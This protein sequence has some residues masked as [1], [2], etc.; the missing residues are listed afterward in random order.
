MSNARLEQ[1]LARAALERA[2]AARRRGALD[3]ALDEL[4]A[5]WAAVRDRH[6]ADAIDMLT[7]EARARRPPVTDEAQWLHRC[8]DADAIELGRLLDKLPR[9]LSLLLP[10]LE[11]LADRPPDPRLASVAMRLREIE[12]WV[13]GQRFMA[14][15]LDPI[16]LAPLRQLRDL[17][18]R[19]GRREQIERSVRDHEQLA[20]MRATALDLG[21]RAWVEAIVAGES[22]PRCAD[23]RE[24]ALLVEIATRPRAMGPRAVYADLLLERGDPFG[25]LV[26]L[27]LRIERRRD[28]GPEHDGARERIA[29]LLADHGETWLGN[30]AQ[31]LEPET[32]DWRA[33][34][35]LRGALVGFDGAPRLEH[36]Q[37]RWLE[38]HPG[39]RT[40]E[41]LDGASDKLSQRLARLGQS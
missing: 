36:W 35:G 24:L 16:Y 41:I 26:T 28:H 18:T 11:R 20:A 34:F 25:E 12:P 6:L 39:L 27:Q 3:L 14:P 21:G 31:I 7:H 5:A 38:T 15:H 30:L 10:G 19:A 4:L 8:A 33:G 29:A 2:H 22:P 32:L 1:A 17:D 37:E 40:F 13:L 9:R 23:A